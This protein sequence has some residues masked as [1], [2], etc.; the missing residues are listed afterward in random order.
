MKSKV[1]SIAT[2]P[3]TFSLARLGD[4]LCK[5]PLCFPPTKILNIL[6]LATLLIALVG[7]FSLLAFTPKHHPTAA[8]ESKKFTT[9]A[10]VWIGSTFT[11]GTNTPTTLLN[12]ASNWQTG[13]PSC[14]GGSNICA[15][16][17]TYT[18]TAPTEQQVINAVKAEYDRLLA[19]SPSPGFLDATFVDGYSW[20]VTINSVS[21]TIKINLQS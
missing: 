9:V 14:N 8:K 17:A 11:V 13:T 2:R 12:T 1:P 20:T 3:Q 21:V 4:T 7:T 16:S 15:A 6:S 19:I 10:Y 18:G 5:P